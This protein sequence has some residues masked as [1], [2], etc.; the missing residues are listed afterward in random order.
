MAS[1]SDGG[2][3]GAAEAVGAA[4]DARGLTGRGFD[5]IASGRLADDTVRGGG[6]TRV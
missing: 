4:E 5:T 3:E 2:E 6:S 1:I